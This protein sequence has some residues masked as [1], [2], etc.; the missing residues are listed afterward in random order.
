MLLRTLLEKKFILKLIV[1][2]EIILYNKTA[3]LLS[4]LF[5][6]IQLSFYCRIVSRLI[7][8]LTLLKHNFIIFR[9]N[10]IL[11]GVFSLP[12]LGG[13]EQIPS[14]LAPKP[15]MVENSNFACG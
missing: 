6:S 4:I 9:F 7:V 13:R 5:K 10:P 8:M 11:G 12:I 15:E 3:V 14:N 2:A 1:T